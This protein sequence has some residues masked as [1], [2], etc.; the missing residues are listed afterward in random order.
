MATTMTMIP[1]VIAAKLSAPQ[2]KR[3]QRAM[4]ENIKV[5][6]HWESEYGDYMFE[7]VG[8]SGVVFT[9]RLVDGGHMTCNC[10]DM[11]TLC[12]RD[13][14]NAMVCKHCCFVLAK[15]M[16]DDRGVFFDRNDLR[17]DSKTHR[18]MY[19]RC[20][21]EGVKPELMMPVKTPMSKRIMDREYYT[22]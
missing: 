5:L 18:E 22:I 2:R 14:P 15:V 7:I 13:R 6:D 8:K 1:P 21:M 17:F 10:P 19:V 12:H 4:T 9:T 16:G 11:L 3:Y 20:K